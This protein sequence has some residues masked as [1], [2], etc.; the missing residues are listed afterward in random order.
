[1]LPIDLTGKIAVVTG[2]SGQ[3]GRVLAR[4]LARC[5]ADVALHAS[6]GSSQTAAE[7]AASAARRTHLLVAD[8]RQADAPDRLVAETIDTFGRPFITA[9]ALAPSTRFWA[10]RGPAP[11]WTNFVMISGA[12]LV[13]GR[14]ARTSVVT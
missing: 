1:M 11:Q 5:G 8:L 9:R 10:A 13:C 7:I 3:L 2:A 14:V 4:T 12:P 6:S